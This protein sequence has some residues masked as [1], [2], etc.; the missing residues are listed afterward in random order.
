MPAPQSLQRPRRT[1]QETMGMLSYARMD[2]PHEPHA[3]GGDTTERPAGTRKITTLRKEPMRE[4]KTPRST[5]GMSTASQVA[6]GDQGARLWTGQ[7]GNDR[8]GAEIVARD[9]DLSEG[10]DRVV[11]NRA[12]G[13]RVELAVPGEV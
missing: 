4:P 10:I 8:P 13:P 9:A 3:L 6:V 12:V 7:R 5:A 2:A 1:S 11:D